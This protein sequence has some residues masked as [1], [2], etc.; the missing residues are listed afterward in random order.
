MSDADQ[1]QSSASSPSPTPR[2]V[3]WWPALLIVC[4]AIA[5]LISIWFIRDLTRQD[6]IIRTLT[7]PLVA[8]ILLLI[9]CVFFSRLPKRIR[10]T[11]VGSVLGLLGVAA[12]LFRHRGFTGD[13]LPIFEPRWTKPAYAPIVP[14]P[15]LRETTSNVSTAASATS[16]SDYPQFLG[17]NRNCI[18][19]GPK[20]ARD[21]IAQPPQKLWR[22][23]IGT[24]WSAF[25][26]SGQ[27]AVTQEQRGEQELVTCYEFMTGKLLWAH[28]DNVRYNTP[29]AGEGPRATPAISDNRVLAHGATGILNCLDLATGKLFWSKNVVADSRS[30]PSQWGMSSSPLIVDDLVVLNGGESEEAKRKRN[31]PTGPALLAY[32]LGDGE[33]A[34]T[35]GTNDASYSSPFLASLAGARQ[36]LSFN[37]N[38]ISAHAP[39]TGGLLW[40]HP[41]EPKNP[42]VAAPVVVSEN[43]VLFSS[44]Y[45]YGSELLE[46][47]MA[48][49]GMLKAKQLWKSNRLKAKFNNL[50][51][52]D[53]FI[54]GLDDGILT[55]LDAS[56]GSLKWKEGRYGHGQQ[57]LVGDLLLLL[58]EN[59]EV[60]LIELSPRESR[61]LTRFAAL[62]S[63]TWNPP[64]LAGDLLLVRNDKE[65]ACYRL[66]VVK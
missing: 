35:S 48:E 42:H 64:A 59:G 63:K 15:A 30:L 20:L 37:F 41:W 44:G 6:Q 39:A 12:A 40:C 53:G 47:N 45:G 32:R 22:Q 51:L 52:R 50:V 62:G 49:G 34:W 21:W 19:S 38:E 56:D 61:V 10:L 17:P 8:L 43:R 14:A 9:W 18:V 55:C 65:A 57:I 36:V 23:P 33:L 7:T 25:A 60:L 3:R 28:A 66:P 54:Y 2:P 4:L 26:V 29:I 13:M 58:A 1:P 11:A 27:F 5:N 24:A 31:E 16:A 46:I